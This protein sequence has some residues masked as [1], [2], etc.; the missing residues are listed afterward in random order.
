[1]MGCGGGC[2]IK[3][4]CMIHEDFYLKLLRPK[5]KG[6]SQFKRIVAIGLKSIS[7]CSLGY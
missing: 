5:L 1:M 7:I 4:N 6:Q 2:K 3:H